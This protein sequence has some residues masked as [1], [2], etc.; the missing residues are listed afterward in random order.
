MRFMFLNLSFLS[1]VL[2]LIAHL[3]DGVVLRNDKLWNTYPDFAISVSR[4]LQR[5]CLFA[6]IAAF[7]CFVIAILHLL[8]GGGIN[9][10]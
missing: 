5:S 4:W 3:L 10:L 2:S 9:A 7:V 1:L 8:T 6:A